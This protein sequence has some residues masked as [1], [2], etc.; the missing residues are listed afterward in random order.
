[1]FSP[2][3]FA[4]TDAARALLRSLLKRAARLPALASP[5]SGA[6]AKPPPRAQ[7]QPFKLRPRHHLPDHREF[8]ADRPTSNPERRIG[9]TLRLLLRERPTG[10]RA[11]R[12]SHRRG[13]VLAALCQRNALPHL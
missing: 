2:Q 11:I 4:R 12:A 3:R 5:G 8:R 1:M 13:G 7:R 9:A 10:L 6:G